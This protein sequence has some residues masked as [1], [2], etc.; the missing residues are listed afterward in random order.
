MH[1]VSPEQLATA[2]AFDPRN[3]DDAEYALAHP[4]E[5]DADTLAACERTARRPENPYGSHA[6]NADVCNCTTCNMGYP[7]AAAHRRFTE[8]R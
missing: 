1:P 2:Q 5:F 3:F 6:V 7:C 8:A 4:S